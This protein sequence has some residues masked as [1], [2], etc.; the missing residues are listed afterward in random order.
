MPVA[1]VSLPR[2]GYAGRGCGRARDWGKRFFAH[3]NFVKRPGNGFGR[4]GRRLRQ[5]GRVRGKRGRRFRLHFWQGGVAVV[6]PFGG[7]IGC[8]VE[9]AADFRSLG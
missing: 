3:A 5:R 1:R 9:S 8:V 6:F 7:A 2:Q 4:K